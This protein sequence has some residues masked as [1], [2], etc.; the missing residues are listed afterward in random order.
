MC[1]PAEDWHHEKR[2]E[3]PSRKLV[4]R[5]ALQAAQQKAGGTKSMVYCPAERWQYEKRG[6]LPS[7]RP[8]A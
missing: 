4:A 3:L 2:A 5:E 1:C 6:V 8:A 7:R